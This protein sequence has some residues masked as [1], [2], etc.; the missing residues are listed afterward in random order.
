M[1]TW[2]AATSLGFAAGVLSIGLSWADQ[3]ASAASANVGPTA[4]PAMDK[5]IAELE[6]Q[7]A[8]ITYEVPDS[9]DR[10]DQ[11][12]PLLQEAA[13][14]VGRYPDRAEPLIWAGII[15][16][17][18]AADASMLNALSHA[19]AAKALFERAEQIDPNALHGAIPMSLGVLYYRVPGFPL[20][21]GDDEQA[22]ALLQKAL[23][24]DPDGLDANYFYGDFLVQQSEY[25][26]AQA[27]LTHALQA[28][29]EPT[30]PVWEAGRRA[31]VQ[32]L[33]DE[34]NRELAE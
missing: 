21:F 25:Q 22:R 7:W 1:R 24:M 2:F 28:P 23:A 16:S 13:A 6:R 32:A 29:V 18:E 17:E 5:D 20:G 34:A 33:L 8:H 19:E 12:Q 3:A 27:V 10:F 30:R 11:L 15:T 31:E 9:D 14:V 26:S 4:N